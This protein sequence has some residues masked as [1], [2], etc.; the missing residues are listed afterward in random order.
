[1][2]GALISRG[3]RIPLITPFDP[4]GQVDIGA[5]AWSA[6]DYLDAGAA[7]V[8]LHPSE[9]GVDYALLVTSAFE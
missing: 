1:M 2:A 5:M 8:A 3:V 7:M 4:A 6:G 9:L